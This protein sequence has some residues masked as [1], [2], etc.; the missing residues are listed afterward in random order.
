MRP[1][2]PG[3]QH[4]HTRK[5]AVAR[6]DDSCLA[7]QSSMLLC[8]A[9]C[10]ARRAPCG[11]GQPIWPIQYKQWSSRIADMSLSL[12]RN[13]SSASFERRALTLLQWS[14]WR[15]NFQWLTRL[16]RTRAWSAE[17][18]DVAVLRLSAMPQSAFA[19]RDAQEAVHPEPDVRPATPLQFCQ[20]AGCRF[21]RRAWS[22]VPEFRI[23]PKSSQTLTKC[24]NARTS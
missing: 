1:R 5:T 15:V 10:A 9:L 19:P 3:L 11:S 22:Q 8:A 18:R 13:K 7:V 16:G 21:R 6:S 4:L 24:H 17:E 14:Q 12:P 2:P 23:P 20:Q